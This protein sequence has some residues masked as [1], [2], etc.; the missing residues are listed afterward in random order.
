M[1]DSDENSEEEQTTPLPDRFILYDED[2]EII[3]P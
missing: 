2:F 3:E 1:K